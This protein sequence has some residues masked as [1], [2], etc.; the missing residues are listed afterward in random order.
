[1]DKSNS[2]KDNCKTI[3]HLNAYLR[4][5]AQNHNNYKTYSKFDRI[6]EILDTKKLY[7]SNGEK[8]NDEFDKSFFNY[9]NNS[10]VNFGKC[11]SFSKA[12]SVAMWML[13]GGI[14]NAGALIDFT[15]KGMKSILNTPSVKIGDF[16]NNKFKSVELK[17]DEFEIYLTD[18]LYYTNN[19]EKYCV[20]RS[21]EHCYDLSKEIFN[22]LNVAKKLYGWKYE[23]ECR[24]IV[25][26][27][28]EIIG[29]IPKDINCKFV[30]I[31]LKNIDLGKSFERVYRGPNNLLPEAQKLL[32]SELDGTIKWSLCDKEKC[33]YEKG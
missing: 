13:Y 25:S 12:E 29:N 32:P 27:S 11:F 15:K 33:P 20:S 30:Q 10:I 5:K 26:I 19:G 1:M 4:Q 22:E 18:V 7:L 23:N 2:L 8:W 14:N 16:D 28:K 6:V 24:L 3:E 17:K 31:C 21:D 9:D